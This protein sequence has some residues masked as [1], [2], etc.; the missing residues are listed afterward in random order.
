MG[1]EFRA[2]AWGCIEALLISECNPKLK[3]ELKPHTQHSALS[4]PSIEK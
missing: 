4:E 2:L 1:S 3:L